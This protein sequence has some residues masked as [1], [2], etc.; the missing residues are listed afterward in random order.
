MNKQQWLSLQQVAICAPEAPA[1]ASSAEICTQY[2]DSLQSPTS[3]SIINVEILWWKYFHYIHGHHYTAKYSPQ[4]NHY[5]IGMTLL[6]VDDSLWTFVI[7]TSQFVGQ[8][9][10]PQGTTL[11]NHVDRTSQ[12][13]KTDARSSEHKSI[14]EEVQLWSLWLLTVGQLNSGY[15]YNF[16]SHC[17][18]KVSSLTIATWWCFHSPLLRDYVSTCLC[19]A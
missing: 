2:E 16:S 9:T 15:H 10:R 14:K 19:H 6:L 8:L 18:M 11:Y 3:A 5:V 1:G 4:Y 17:P 12:K 7:A 13:E